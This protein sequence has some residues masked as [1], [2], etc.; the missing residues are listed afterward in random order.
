MGMHENV[1]HGIDSPH[2]YHHPT[3]PPGAPTSWEREPRDLWRRTVERK[4]RG[5][6]RGGGEGWGLLRPEP[7]SRCCRVTVTLGRSLQPY[8]RIPH[9]KMSQRRI[10][11][12][13]ALTPRS[14]NR[15]PSTTQCSKDPRERDQSGFLLLASQ[16]ER[17]P[18]A[19]ST[20]WVASP[21][22]SNGGCSRFKTIH[23]QRSHRSILNSDGKLA[24]L[25]PE[26]SR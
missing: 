18:G 17:P 4:K 21:L 24:A 1:W 8:K 13:R 7:G 19:H 6:G 11:P 25:W 23:N 14:G 3:C 15:G 2:R 12:P 10:L 16:G 5:W 26:L 9:L 20:G 22:T